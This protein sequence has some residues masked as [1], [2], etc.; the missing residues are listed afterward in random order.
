M[1][2]HWLTDLL[3]IGYLRLVNLGILHCNISEGSV[4]LVHTDDAYTHR[5]RDDPDTQGTV[6]QGEAFPESERELKEVLNKMNWAPTGILSC[7]DPHATH[8]S[9]F[10]STSHPR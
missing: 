5:E 2:P 9:I 6:L 1:P 3:F 10:Q 7:F 4:L 8:P